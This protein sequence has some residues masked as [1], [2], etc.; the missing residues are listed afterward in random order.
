MLGVMTALTGLAYPAFV[1]TCGHT[2]F[3]RQA[4]GSLMS[5]NGVVI[6]SE[7][8]AQKTADPRY[9]MPR[10][11]GGDFATVPSGAGNQAWT[12]AALAKAI[13]DR[14][15]VYPAGAAVP[16]DLVTASGSGLDPDLSPTAIQLQ[17]DRVAA[18]RRLDG[19]QRRALDSL[20]RRETAGGRWTPARVNVL[21]LNLALD[22]IYP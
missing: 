7:L 4:E 17:V 9:F 6:G 11:S 1:W 8:L 20:I 13:A 21:K 15:A 10:P 2:L 22:E 18:A 5:R 14:R 3:R 12:S 19:R 16:A